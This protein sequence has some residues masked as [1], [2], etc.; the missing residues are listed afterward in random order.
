MVWSCESDVI[1]ESIGTIGQSTMSP[2]TVQVY[3]K[4]SYFLRLQSKPEIDQVIKNDSVAILANAID[5]AA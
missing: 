1:S 4:F 5:E 2:K 3:T